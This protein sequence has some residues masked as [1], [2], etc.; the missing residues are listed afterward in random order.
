MKARLPA[1]GGGAERVLILVHKS[2]QICKK[3]KRKD[4]K[5]VG[6]ESFPG[7]LPVRSRR[8]VG[9]ARR[10]SPPDTRG[11]SRKRKGKD[12]ERLG[13]AFELGE[14]LTVVG[15]TLTPGADTPEFAL[16]WLNPAD[17]TVH[18]V[19][20]ADTDGQVRLLTWSTRWDTPVCHIETRRWDGLRAELPPAA[21]STPSAWTCRSR[22]RAGR[23]RRASPMPFYPPTAARSSARI[24]ASCSKNGVC[25]QRGAT[26]SSLTGPGDRPCRICRGPDD[27]AGLLRRPEPP[28]EAQPPRELFHRF[29]SRPVTT[30]VLPVPEHSQTIRARPAGTG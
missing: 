3:T 22:R 5:A 30:S 9:N 26:C 19:R 25:W 15:D 14:T 24:T 6:K 4:Q 23:R 18:A 29:L 7:R 1:A 8:K 11:G 16:D 2:C 10:N 13:G 21:W 27:R 12:A 17:A 20:L 28:P